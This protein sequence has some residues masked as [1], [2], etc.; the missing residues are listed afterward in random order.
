MADDSF[1]GGTHQ[2]KGVIHIGHVVD[3]RFADDNAQTLGPRPQLFDAGSP[4]A[5][6]RGERRPL[7]A[8]HLNGSGSP[9]GNRGQLRD[10]VADRRELLL[11]CQRLQ[12]GHRKPNATQRLIK[13]IPGIR[14]ADVHGQLL[15]GDAELLGVHAGHL[16][17]K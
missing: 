3:L 4:L 12:F 7:L 16:G 11:R 10:G 2:V 15:N 9:I 8:K 17:R 1:D 14:L 6:Q 5:E 13:G